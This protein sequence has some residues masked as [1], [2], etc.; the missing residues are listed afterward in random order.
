MILWKFSSSCLSDVTGLADTG[1]VA[2]RSASGSAAGVGRREGGG[3]GGGG[4]CVRCRG[5]SRTGQENALETQ[6]ALPGQRRP[7]GPRPTARPRRLQTTDGA[8]GRR[9]RQ[10]RPTRRYETG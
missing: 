10:R 8:Q 6:V 2:G 1:R 3:G 7:S 9:P 5:G 4:W